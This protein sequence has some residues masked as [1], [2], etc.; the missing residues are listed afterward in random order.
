MK[1]ATQDA[2]TGETYYRQ[3]V[4]T[5]LAGLS[6]EA[7]KG[8]DQSQVQER[9][10]QSGP[11]EL[12]ETG[13]R[14]PWRILWAQLTSMMELILIAAAGI[15]F[16]L[17][18]YRDAT[19]ILAIVLLFALLGFSQEYRAEKAMAALKK[20]TV[21]Q[22]KV[23]RQGL[24]CEITARELVPGDIVL[25]EA[26][27]MVPADGRIL[28]AASLRVQEA[29]LTGESEAVEKNT[30]AIQTPDPALGDRL[31]MVYMSTLVTN[32]R[33]EVVV[34]ATGMQ[35]EL[36]KIAA[37]IQQVEP[38]ASPLQQRL[39]HLGKMLAIGAVGISLLMLGLG[40]LRG[41]DLKL[42]LMSAVSL[43]VAVVPEGLPAVMTITLALGAQRMLKQKA[44][45]RKLTGVETLGSV[46]V[47]CSDK[48][49]TLTQ[50]RMNVAALEVAGATHRPEVNGPVAAPVHLF[51][52][53]ALGGSLC[54]DAQLQP[55]SSLGY[56]GDPT[57]GALLLAAYKMGIQK[58][59]LEAGLPRIAELPFDSERKRMSTVHRRE[60]DAP[61]PDLLA[62]IWPYLEA[63]GQIENGS[64]LSFTKG[65][66]DQVLSQCSH[67]CTEAGIVPLTP[68]WTRK[69]TEANQAMAQEGMRILALA[70]AQKPDL[71]E[72]LTP[73]SL[74][75]ELS[76]VGLFALIDPPRP[77]AKQ[78][79]QT[80]LAAGIRP[81]MITGDHPLTASAIAQE[82]K[83][84][85]NP[86]VLTGAEL[87]KMSLEDLTEQVATIS[88]Y[89]RVSPE[90]KLKI[91]AA[92]QKRGEIVAMTGDGVNDAPSLKKADIG[93]AMGV[94]GTDVAK[95]AATM[96]LLDDNFATI[97]AA[98]EQGRV[99]YD[100]IRKFIK[101]SIAGN[102]AKILAMLIT[103]F[104]G[105]PL[106]LLPLQLLWLNLLTDGLLGLG[107]GMEPGERDTMTRPPVPPGE[108]VLGQGMAGQIVR[109]G[110][111]IGVLA[112]GVSYGYWLQGDVHWQTL[113]FAT[114]AFAQMFQ[115]LATRSSRDS[116]F[117]IGFFSN[118]TL[119]AMLGT[120]FVLQL[121]VIY[122][123]LLSNFLHTEALPPLCLA[124][125]L[126]LSSLV[127]W[128]SE[129]EKF[130]QRRAGKKYAA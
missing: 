109:T 100:N 79:I 120:T 23:R 9:L 111:L 36:G 62:A 101:F 124:V 38:A 96:V 33:A 27:N 93:V 127:L 57:E 5:V 107:L 122:I 15:S 103:P 13:I 66:P 35:T 45:V 123:P 44:L 129:I 75:T 108:S 77:E 130:F 94:N 61:G 30:A 121:A 40:L 56:L 118:P 29:S 128:V 126:G 2:P 39:D 92:L 26:G 64:L 125:S 21:P 1:T 11:N 34:V 97:V 113:L 25:L 83:I 99:I 46:T 88:V 70:L 43:A 59:E 3:D 55:D 49:G 80:C 8:L 51:T 104:L 6:V 95:E 19:V 86:Q 102:L 78:A 90:H 18:V 7:Q 4:Q 69:I 41:E 105:M 42:M 85:D 76:F 106:A 116:I 82:L 115:A 22:V 119:L 58:H 48:T 50:N 37:L 20:L 65:A 52:L 84:T 67:V 71:P 91:I 110:L 14:S 81:V 31:N 74:E 72:P 24:V 54:N 112:L 117:T 87:E 98:I 32:G 17:G 68:D 16:L 89:A 63:S 53:L 73:E 12:L 60:P 114:I 47:I 28:S 10:G